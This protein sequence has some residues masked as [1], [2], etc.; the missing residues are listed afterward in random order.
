M[1][2]S[3]LAIT[4]AGAPA[5][6]HSKIVFQTI[7]ELRGGSLEYRAGRVSRFRSMR[8]FNITLALTPFLFFILK[9]LYHM[10]Q[11]VS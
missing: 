7:D 4:L 10:F 3:A 8:P 11:F 2:A 1:E 5:L 9:F 6:M